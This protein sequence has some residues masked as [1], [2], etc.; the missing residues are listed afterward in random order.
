MMTG[1]LEY[2]GYYVDYDLYYPEASYVLFICFVIIVPI[3]FM[4]LLVSTLQGTISFCSCASLTF[5]FLG[6]LGACKILFGSF[7]VN[8]CCSIA[9]QLRLINYDHNVQANVMESLISK[10]V[11]L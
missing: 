9:Y 4:N 10:L 3:V 7:P 6:V 8:E 2:D 5:V 1:E 11:T